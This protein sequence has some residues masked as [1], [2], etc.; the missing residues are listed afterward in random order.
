MRDEDD[1]IDALMAAGSRAEPYGA[2]DDLTVE[3]L[4]KITRWKSLPRLPA[5][6]FR[7]SRAT[8]EI[9]MMDTDT[10]MR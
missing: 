1:A 10:R 6:A 9:K 7:A 5:G 3:E 2:D 4:T 8:D